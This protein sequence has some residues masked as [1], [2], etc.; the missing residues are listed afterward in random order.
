MTGAL[1]DL[2]EEEDAGSSAMPSL[3]VALLLSCRE[4]AN[5]GLASLSTSVRELQPWALPASQLPSPIKWL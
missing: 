2:K 3:G 1:A 5:V 4:A